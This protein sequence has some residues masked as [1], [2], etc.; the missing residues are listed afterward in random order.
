MKSKSLSIVLCFFCL[1]I[2]A[3]EKPKINK[4]KKAVITSLDGKFEELK[5]LSD[6]IWGF[7]EIAFRET[8]SAEALAKYAESQ[9][10]TVKRGVADIPTALVAEY[11]SGKP[12]IG[13]LGEFDALPGLS[14][15]T[16]PHKDPAMKE[17]PVMAA[18]TTSLE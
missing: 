12:I 9:G 10:F 11:G 13:I 16:V 8:Q 2:Y 14:Q 5:D 15:N 18:D 1:S 3:Q 17:E 7:E 6:R 4:N